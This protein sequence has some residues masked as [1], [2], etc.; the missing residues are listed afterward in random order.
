[1]KTFLLLL[2]KVAAF[3]SVITWRLH[4]LKKLT[5]TQFVDLDV[6][7]VAIS[8]SIN[9]HISWCI[10]HCFKKLITVDIAPD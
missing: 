8:C 9:E 2:D 6:W 4:A 7:V 3:F 1:M 10:P 5:L